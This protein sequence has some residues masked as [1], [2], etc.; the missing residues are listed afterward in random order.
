MKVNLEVCR[1][2]IT[3]RKWCI[4]SSLYKFI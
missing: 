4:Y 1:G 2:K 3:R